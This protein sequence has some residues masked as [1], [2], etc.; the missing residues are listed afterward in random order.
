MLLTDRQAFSRRHPWNYGDARARRRDVRHLD[1]FR[2]AGTC[3]ILLLTSLLQ[4]PALAQQAGQHGFDPRQSEKHFDRLANVAS[5]SGRAFECQ[6]PPSRRQAMTPSRWSCF[7]VFRS[8]APTPFRRI[9][10]RPAFSLI[11]ERTSRRPTSQPSPQQSAI[12]IAKPAFISAAPLSLHKTFS[13]GKFV[14]MSL[15]AAS[16]KSS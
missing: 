2:I 15:R 7:A 3:S 9:S 5:L 1:T 13:T 6:L 8:P 10:Y 14:L 12:C 11:W 16:S 4:G